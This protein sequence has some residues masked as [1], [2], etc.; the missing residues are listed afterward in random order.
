MNLIICVDET[1]G[2]SF[3]G[4]RQSMDSILREKAL[5]LTGQKPLWMDPYSAGQFRDR[6]DRI[7]V[8]KEYWDKV[9]DNGW[10]FFELGDPEQV[11][12]R[13]KCL[14]V[15]HWNRAYPADRFFPLERIRSSAA[16]CYSEAFAGNSHDK[17][18]MEVYQL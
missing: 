11:L 6:M 5:S 7:C 14:V 4:R 10:C 16:L 9:P 1:F 17:I 8:V 15:F 3:F 12:A 13:V 18:T 2:C